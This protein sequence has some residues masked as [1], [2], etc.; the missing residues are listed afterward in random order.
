MT[1]LE[2]LIALTLGIFLLG[3]ILV[4]YLGSSQSYRVTENTSRLQEGARFAFDKLAGTIRMAGYRGC[5]T[6]WPRIIANP[7]PLFSA[8]TVLVGEEAIAAGTYTGSIAGTDAITVRRGSAHS[9]IP[10]QT[11][12]APTPDASVDIPLFATPSLLSHPFNYAAGHLLLISDCTSADL[13][14][15]S[16]VTGTSISHAVACNT[17]TVNAA[18]SNKLSAPYGPDAQVMAYEESVFYIRANP[19][20]R[21]ALYLQ[22]RSGGA[23]TTEELVEGVQDMQFCYGEDTNGNAEVDVYRTAAAVANWANVVSVRISLLL[24]T[25]DASV[26]SAATAYALDRNCDGD[27]TD[28]GE[29]IAAT[30][31]LH[32]VITSTVGVRNRLP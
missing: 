27:T 14:C 23:A 6:G 9:L 1:L 32:R 25:N 22:S 2:L 24:A 28:A 15:A 18:D 17:D 8:A 7:A 21:N 26:A 31:R 3:G 12:G 4:V 30:R 13:F 29:T 20:G 11:M 10:K 16:G 5:F 19:A